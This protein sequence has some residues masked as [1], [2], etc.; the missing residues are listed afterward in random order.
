MS[1][2]NGLGMLLSI[3]ASSARACTTGARASFRSICHRPSPFDIRPDMIV[4]IHG[5]WTMD[6]AKV[7]QIALVNSGGAA[8]VAAFNVLH[9]RLTLFCRMRIGLKD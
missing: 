4:A 6:T 1:G 5:A 8:T 3:I 9:R 7:D 2:P